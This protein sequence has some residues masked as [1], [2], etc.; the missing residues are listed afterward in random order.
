MSRHR[1]LICAGFWEEK[2][3]TSEQSEMTQLQQLKQLVTFCI[4]HHHHP[5]FTKKF[6]IYKLGLNIIWEVT[7]FVSELNGFAEEINP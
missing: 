5:P 3:P 6:S 4:G 1:S 2:S 7:F